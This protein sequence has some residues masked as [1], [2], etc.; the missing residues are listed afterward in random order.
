MPHCRNYR[1]QF[2]SE[3]RTCLQGIATLV[4]E[5]KSVPGSLAE[6]SSCR[7]VS[8]NNLSMTIPSRPERCSASGTKARWK[9]A[10]PVTAAELILRCFHKSGLGVESEIVTSYPCYADRRTPRSVP[11][12]TG[13]RAAIPRCSTR[14]RPCRSPVVRAASLLHLK[15]SFCNGSPR[16]CS[17]KPGTRTHTLGR[18][19]DS[20]GLQRGRTSVTAVMARGKPLS[21]RNVLRVT[22]CGAFRRFGEVVPE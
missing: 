19:V 13:P 8:C 3:S 6:Q 10:N 4:Y 11:T 18:G 17:V 21:T 5:R 15:A 2:L 22:G 12:T 7:A 16:D 20:P 14:S 1:H 9:M